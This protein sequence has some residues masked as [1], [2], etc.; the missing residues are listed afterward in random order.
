[1]FEPSILNAIED[2]L[3]PAKFADETRHKLSSPQLP[4]SEIHKIFA[5]FM[6]VYPFASHFSNITR[7][8]YGTGTA[9]Y[10]PSALELPWD[11]EKVCALFIF[12]YLH[13]LIIEQR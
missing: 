6:K 11:I 1:M 2:I 4:F 13:G 12:R 8:F 3:G 5:E 9:N 7:T 10:S